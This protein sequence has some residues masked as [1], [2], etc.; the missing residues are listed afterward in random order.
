MQLNEV[1]LYKHKMKIETLICFLVGSLIFTPGLSANQ[2]LPELKFTDYTVENG[3]SYNSVL[4]IC[5]DT[6]GIIWFATNDGLNR[7]NGHDIYI[8]R[9]RHG[10]MTSLPGNSLQKVMMDKDH[11]LWACTSNGLARYDPIGETFRKADIPGTTSIEDLVQIDS[12]QFLVAT[13]NATYIYNKEKDTASEFRLDEDSPLTFF[14][15]CKDGENIILCTR[16]R[17]VETLHLVDG[18]LSRKYEPMKIPKFGSFPI[19]AG[20]ERYYIG[21]KGAGLILA[22]VRKGGYKTILSGNGGWMQVSSLEYDQ[23]GHLWV[24]SDAG[25]FI[26]DGERCIYQSEFKEMKDKTINCIFKDKSGGMWIGTE[27]AGV[28][29][30]SKTRDKFNSYI[31]PGR[32]PAIEDNIITCI[33]ND[34]YGAIWTGTRYHGLDRYFPETGKHSHYNINNVRTICLSQDGKHAYAGMEINGMRSINLQ[35]GTV[36]KLKSPLD[37]MSIQEAQNGKLWLGTLVGLYLYDPDD[38]TSGRI[39]PDKENIFVRILNLTKDSKGRLWVGAKENLLV[40]QTTEN[41]EV[42]DVTPPAVR[43]FVQVQCIHESPDSTIWIGSLDG[44]ASYKENK[45]GEGRLQY[46]TCLKNTTI[47]GI[48]EDHKGNLWI[49]SDKGLYRYKRTSGDLRRYNKDDG[50]QC[51]L[52]NAC[53]HARDASGK[54]YFGGTNGIEVF[55]PDKMPVNT[56]TFKPMITELVVNNATIRPDDRYGILKSNIQY[57]DKITLKHWQNSLTLHFSCTDMVSG[58]SNT[59][60]YKL[61]GFDKYWNIARGREATYT[62]LDKG[63]YVFLLKV[64]NNDGY[65]SETPRRLE[66]T[67]KPAWY[68]STATRIIFAILVL[69]ALASLTRWFLKHTET[70]KAKEIA[71][72]T[73]TYEEKVQKTK[74]EMLV[75]SSYNLKS[76]EETFLSS[77]LA[78]IEKNIGNQDFTVEA[79]A[80][81]A[82]ITRGNLHLKLKNLT[83]KTPVELIKTMRMKRACELMKETDLSIAD[84]AEQTGFQTPGYFITVFKNHFGETPGHYASRVRQQ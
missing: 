75:D 18:K 34:S 2:D 16:W 82:C 53:A 36:R 67:V 71:Q 46:I 17:M 13:R 19:P 80:S 81:H 1:K 84:I 57:T 7:F 52:F 58:E 9:H 61:E 42:T 43:D 64:S 37:I 22:D 68:R 73:K 83:G 44:L 51:N 31:I 41:N 76:H 15:S 48:E 10:D 54:M 32:V 29:Y 21:T 69:G 65:W 5:Q 3:L 25:L 47:R 27:F 23:D 60:Q 26:L 14:S 45:D 33:Y 56:D 4:S 35:N 30:W 78:C 62:N 55:H 79:L 20:N 6:T 39:F 59:F 28:K 63:K 49:S 74:L 8:Y 66:I 12:T 50:L 38:D 24:G 70:V 11:L 72:I 77:V 40:L